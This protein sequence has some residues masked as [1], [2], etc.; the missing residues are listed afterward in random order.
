MARRPKKEAAVL[1]R[2]LEKLQ[3]Y[4]G[5]IKMMRRLPDIVI[6]V[7]QRREHNAIMECQKLGIPIIS[8]LDTNCDPS[9]VDIP[10]PANDDAIRSVKLIIGKLANAIYEG[11][12]GQMD[13]ETEAEYEEFDE[14]IGTYEDEY[15]EEEEMT[16]EMDQEMVA[17]GD[18]EGE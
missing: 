3:K 13:M 11:R 17:A 7:D 15:M 6:I 1:G 10:I 12:H 14:G 2:E 4:L 16:S 5:G 8:M 18:T 9:L